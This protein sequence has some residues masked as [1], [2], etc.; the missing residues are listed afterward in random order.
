[1]SASGLW[2]HAKTLS[3]DECACLMSGGS[4]DEPKTAEYRAAIAIL[5]SGIEAD[6][7]KGMFRCE[8]SETDATRIATMNAE[9]SRVYTETLVAY[10]Q[11]HSIN[12]A[13]FNP[14]VADGWMNPNFRFYAPRVGATLEGW[15]FLCTLQELP[16]RQARARVE[17]FLEQ[18][19]AKFGLVDEKG[20]PVS[21]AIGDIL[22]A[23]FHQGE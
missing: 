16:A 4:P 19:A 6:Q 14:G 3:M 17:K 12:D 23:L 22:R 15:Q 10:L 9:L 18:N 21:A 2:K 5:K 8:N 11:K 13:Y 20:E 1:M 7:I